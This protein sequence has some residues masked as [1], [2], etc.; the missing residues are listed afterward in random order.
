MQ[1]KTDKSVFK[2]IRNLQA[3]LLKIHYFCSD[4]TWIII[5]IFGVEIAFTAAFFSFLYSV[6]IGGLTQKL[7]VLS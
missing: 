5:R 3:I 2:H 7:A 6:F 4:V 1:D